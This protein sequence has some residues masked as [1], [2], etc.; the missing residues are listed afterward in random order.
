MVVAKKAEAAVLKAEVFTC[1]VC[2]REYG[3]KRN[4][5]FCSAPCRVQGGCEKGPTEVPARA[6]EAPVQGLRHGLLPARAPEA[7]VQGLRHGPLPARAQEAPVQ[8]LRHGLL[9][10][11]A[12]E[13]LL[14]GLRGTG[15]CEHRRPC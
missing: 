4:Y 7:P 8:G 13:A 12:P 2:P 5:G 14:Q 9:P 6:R 15:H 1:K 11:R 10:A 3:G